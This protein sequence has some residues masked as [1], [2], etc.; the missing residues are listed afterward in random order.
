MPTLG[1]CEKWFNTTTKASYGFSIQPQGGGKDIFLHISAVERAGLS[2]LNDGQA[3][4]YEEV[5]NKAKR[6]QRKF[7]RVRR[8]G[9]GP[10][11]GRW[12]NGE[13]G[14]EA[15]GFGRPFVF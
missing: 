9:S 14:E 10:E 1:T 12:R 15:G 2:S 7:S 8:W 6:Q 3:I 5:S 13:P 4:E 11:C